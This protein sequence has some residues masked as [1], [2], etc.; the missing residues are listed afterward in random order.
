M[1]GD[2][3]SAD[4]S[5]EI[6]AMASAEAAQQAYA[7][8]EQQLQWTQQVWNQE[9]PLMD[10]SE[11]AQIALSTQ[12]QQS[13]A[14]SQA[15]SQAQWD[16]YQQTYAPLEASYAQQAQ[17][18]AS[19][20]AMAQARAQ[21]M[22]SVAEQGTAGLNS[23]AETLRSYGVNPSSPRYAALYTSAQ[24]ML[25]A[26]E[27]AAGT[28]AS[29]NLRLQQMG[30]ESG[31]INTG[32]G[33][34]NSVGT[35]TGAGTQAAS[36]SGNLA[37]GAASTADTNL[38]TGS[39]AMTAPTAWYNAGANNMNSYVNAVNGYN[40]AQAQFAQ[41]GAEEMGGLGSAIGG[42]AGLGMMGYM[43]S[44]ERDKTDI[45]R[46]GTDRDGTPLYSYRYAEDPKH[47]PK[48][49]G[50][51]AQDLLRINPRKVSAIPGSAGTL[52]IQYDDGGDVGMPS[53]PQLTPTQGGGATGIP[54]APIPPAQ[55]PAGDPDATPG[56]GV[57]SSASPSHGQT[58][59]DVPAMLTAN[60]FVIPKDVAVW[61]GHEYFAKQ[62]DAARQGQQRFQQRDDIGGE[63]TAAVPQRPNFVSRPPHMGTTQGAIPGM[64]T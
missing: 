22:S 21:A 19:P 57:P 33:L 59:D 1:G 32:R 28:T 35:L 5:G 9:Q 56:G 23:A 47:Y 52:M 13:L 46:E 4:Q 14:Q 49:V 55:T 50:P 20:E 2:K 18:W 37:Q 63:P 7:L 44:D 39:T 34:V 25:G 15:E 31:A 48:V 11:Q 58:P 41:A 16:E 17:N 60:E 8:G 45:K 62:I 53:D 30:L 61:K 38:S 29:Q 51:M 24:P 43:K 64:P 12:E 27:A 36:T 54:S 6:Q 42:I 40:S 10:Q 3:G 26:A